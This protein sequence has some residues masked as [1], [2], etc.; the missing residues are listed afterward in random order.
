M[1]NITILSLGHHI[2]VDLFIL[3]M[4]FTTDLLFNLYKE[5]ERVKHDITVTWAHTTPKFSNE[6][7][8]HFQ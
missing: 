8:D 6:L 4:L 3:K 5:L 7:Y 1:T 2:T